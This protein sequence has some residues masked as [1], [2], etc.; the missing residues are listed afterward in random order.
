MTYLHDPM[1]YAK[2]LHLQLR[3]GTWTCQ[4][5]EKRYQYASSRE[6][7]DAQMCPCSQSKES[8]THVEGEFEL[9][10]E[11]RGVGG[12]STNV[13]WRSLVH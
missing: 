9:S 8:R 13:T 11:E 6:E 3:V 12:E 2:T 1:D 7:E 5:E 10:N 4:K